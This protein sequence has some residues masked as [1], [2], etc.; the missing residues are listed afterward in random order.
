M[1]KRLLTSEIKD[2]ILEAFEQVGGVEYLVE[3]ARRDPPT[4]CRLLAAIIPSEIKA[5]VTTT[6]TLDLGQAM[7]E[8]DQRLALIEHNLE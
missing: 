3:I 6:H 5:S 2:G 7:I 1:A 8:A 4:F